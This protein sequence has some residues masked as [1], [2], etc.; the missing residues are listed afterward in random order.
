MSLSERTRLDNVYIQIQSTGK[1]GAH[2]VHISEIMRDG[3]AI[4][5]QMQSPESMELAELKEFVA[6]LTE[7]QWIGPPKPEPEPVTEEP[8]LLDA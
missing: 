1:V 4:Q 5:G 8:P 6:G 2:K 3:V 7:E